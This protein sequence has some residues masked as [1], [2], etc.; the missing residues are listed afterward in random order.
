MSE[1]Y[2]RCE[3]CGRPLGYPYG[4]SMHPP[5][6]RVDVEI[7]ILEEQVKKA[8]VDETALAEAIKL[9]RPEATAALCQGI[10]RNVERRVWAIFDKVK[11]ICFEYEGQKH[12]VLYVKGAG[13]YIVD[14]TIKQ[15]LPKEKRTVFH[16]QEYPLEI[17]ELQT[18]RKEV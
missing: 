18:W 17:K 11:Q 9:R 8:W 4:I 7:K 13:V 6:C 1:I 2:E 5:I 12:V 15:F 14:G 10:S 3:K 16:I